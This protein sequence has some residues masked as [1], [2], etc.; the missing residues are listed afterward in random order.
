[1]DVE[2]VERWAPAGRLVLLLDDS[3]V[4]KSG[5]KVDGAGYFHDAATSTAVAHKVSAW[6]LNVV[7]LALRLPSPRGGEPLALPVMVC[8]HRKSKKEATEE[9]EEFSLI[10]LAAWMVLRLVDWPPKATDG[11]GG[12]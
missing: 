9:E 11:A 5:R 8:L 10:E 3:L 2:L 12:P 1:V 4:N 6:G 7:I